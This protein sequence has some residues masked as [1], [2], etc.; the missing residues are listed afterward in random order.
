[1]SLIET[2]KLKYPPKSISVMR[3]ALF[4][5]ETGGT[6]YTRSPTLI[7]SALREHGYT[8]L[9]DK[10]AECSPSKR[11]RNPY[12]DACRKALYDRQRE[13]SDEFLW[14]PYKRDEAKAREN[15]FF[16]TV[17]H[18]LIPFGQP[19]DTIIRFPKKQI[20][21]AISEARLKLK[22]VRRTFKDKINFIGGFE[23]EAV[24]GLLA[25]LHPLKG[26]TLADLLEDPI[27]LDDKFV[28][29][30]SH[31]VVD[32]AEQPLNPFTGDP[33]VT[34]LKARLKKEWPEKKQVEVK[35]LFKAKPVHDSLNRLADYPFKFPI[36]YYYRW[37]AM[38]DGEHLVINGKQ[39]NLARN[40]SPD[41]LAEMVRGVS[42]IGTKALYI[43]MGVSKASEDKE[44]K[45][46]E[47]IE[48]HR[49]RIGPPV[50]MD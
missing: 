35:P 8:E 1:M 14:Y 39:Q 37:N 19:D 15:L 47:K 33:A 31:F 10:M 38:Q 4:D 29:V 30:H 9:A 34:D 40:F 2:L 23:L 24:T 43:R 16:V 42:E 26:Q 11:C 12:C 49:K 32:M 3:Q 5:A 17:L 6:D 18:E 50:D 46:Q 7:N 44:R 25:K 21:S 36:K 27:G 28:L 45:R 48:A 13:K 22:A 41:V 20:K